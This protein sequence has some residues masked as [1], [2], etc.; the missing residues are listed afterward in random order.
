MYPGVG[1][2]SSLRS[3]RLEFLAFQTVCFYHT[4]YFREEAPED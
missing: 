2:G 1:S 3:E 4:G